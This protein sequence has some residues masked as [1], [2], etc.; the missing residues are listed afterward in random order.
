MAFEFRKEV[1]VTN[2][3]N[4]LVQVPRAVATAWDLRIGDK[5]EVRYENDTLTVRPAVHRRGDAS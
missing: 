1:N 5:L 3:K 2:Q 4:I